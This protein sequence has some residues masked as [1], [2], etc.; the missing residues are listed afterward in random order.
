M[1]DGSAPPGPVV[2]RRSLGWKLRSLRE[3]AGKTL[4]DAARELE[5]STATVSRLETG[6]GSGRVKTRDV[7]DLARLYGCS[8]R[9]E[10]DLL[11]WAIDASDEPWY[12]DYGRYLSADRAFAFELESRATQ[13][14]HLAP[15]LIPGPLQTRAYSE[16]IIRIVR[17]A[18]TV[19]DAT[20]TDISALADI[21]EMRQRNLFR[22][23]GPAYSALIDEAVLRR[24]IGGKS[25][26]R[27]QLEWLL[28]ISNR[29]AVSLRILPFHAGGYAGQIGSFTLLSVSLGE[30]ESAVIVDVLDDTLVLL[31]SDDVARYERSLTLASNLSLGEAESQAEIRTAIARFDAS[32][33]P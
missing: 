1:S 32:P 15:S 27:E 6:V 13:V 2:A 33:G 3:A 12:K 8:D 29:P 28:A 21:R 19:S 10:A 7:R 11:T 16:R 22:E 31:E 30:S 20:A 18:E 17:E 4:T 23:G 25:V 9:E 5:T 14:H 26:M 24:Q